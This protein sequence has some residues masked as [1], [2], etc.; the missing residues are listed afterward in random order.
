MRLDGGGTARFIIELARVSALTISNLTL[1]HAADH[2]VFIH[3]DLGCDELVFSRLR[4][5][6]SGG[7]ALRMIGG[8]GHDS[9]RGTVSDCEFDNAGVAANPNFTAYIDVVAGSGWRIA[10]CR[11]HPMRLSDPAAFPTASAILIERRRRGQCRR[12]QPHPRL[13]PR[14]HLGHRR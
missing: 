13:P 6:A 5:G 4:F 1:E 2:L 12:G 7:N 14:H 3:G 9:N 8:G 11:F 10:R